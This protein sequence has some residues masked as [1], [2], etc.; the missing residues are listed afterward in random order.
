MR[1]VFASVRTFCR[2]LPAVVFAMAVHDSPT[3]S[4]A[5]GDDAS[6]IAAEQARLGATL[7]MVRRAKYQVHELAL[8]TGTKVRQFVGE[9]GKVFAVSWSGGWRPNLRDVLGKHYDR[10]I[11]GTRGRR[12][13]RGV[14]RIE[15]PGMVV[16]MGGPQRACFGRVTLTDMLPAGVAPEDLR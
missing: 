16:V 14:A 15:L 10:F 3:A 9:A 2:C 1:L 7:R 13:A 6:A 4:A 5:L 12:V 11:V 8:P